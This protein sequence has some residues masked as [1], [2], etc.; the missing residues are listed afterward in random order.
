MTT[1]VL[2]RPSL[3]TVSGNFGIQ[4]QFFKK[5]NGTLVVSREPVFRSGTFRDSMGYQNT[6]EDIHLQQMLNN[7]D[8]LRNGG[9]LQ[10]VPVRD[11]H[12]GF[13]INGLAGAGKVIGWHTAAVVEKLKAP[14]DGEEYSYFLV[15]YEI[16]DPDA[17]LAY[18]RGQFRNRSAEIMAYVT[19]A[20]AEFWPTYGGFAFVDI[21]AVEGLNFS[22]ESPTTLGRDARVL[23]MFDKEIPSMT[24]PTTPNGAPAIEQRPPLGAPAAQAAA[25]FAFSINGQPVTDY[26]AVQRHIST[27]EGTVAEGRQAA[28][29]AFVTGLAQRNLIQATA[30]ES[31]SQLAASMNDQQWATFCAGYEGAAAV[32]SLS[33]HAAPAAAGAAPVQPFSGGAAVVEDEGVVVAKQ[34]VAGHRINRMPDAQLKQL[35]SYRLLVAKGIEQ[36]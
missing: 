21:P 33:Q 27:L 28:R 2:Q 7:Y 15:D 36:A 35:P 13:L 34:I 16:T 25:P 12:P 22:R 31:F 14:H 5:A 1:S 19:N 18:E 30:I 10:N 17:A 32:A 4:P 24:S 29:T 20:E 23:V 11:G 3:F 8:Y 9:I 26:A 6:W